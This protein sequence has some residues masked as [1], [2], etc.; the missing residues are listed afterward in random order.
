MAI[1]SSFKEKTADKVKEPKHYK[2]IMYNDDFTT[3]EFVVEVLVTVFKK[4]Q[5]MA[6][7]LMLDVH[8][9]GHAVVGRYPFDIAVSKTNKALRMAKEQGFPFK[10]TVEDD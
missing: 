1:Q 4:E 7:A 3:M 8:K 9:K 10:M 5:M 6:E 2:V